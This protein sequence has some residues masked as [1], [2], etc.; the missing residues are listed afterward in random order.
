MA[1]YDELI[2]LALKSKGSFDL[3]EDDLVSFVKAGA[4]RAYK[5]GDPARQDEDVQ[6][7]FNVE[8][9]KL[10]LSLRKKVVEQVTNTH[11]ECTP[12]EGKLPVGEMASVE[13]ADEGTY[14]SIDA[15]I[16]AM[17]KE[18]EA[19]WKQANSDLVKNKFQEMKGACLPAQ[20]LEPDSIGSISVIINQLDAMLPA[21]EQVPGETFHVGQTVLVFVKDLVEGGNSSNIIVSRTAPEV[22]MQALK[23]HIPEVD[24]GNIEVKG[25]ARIPGK[26][27]RIAVFSN[28]MNA[29]ERCE[30]RIEKI[31]GE[32]GKEVVEFIEWYEDIKSFIV[33][34]LRVEARDVLLIEGE[35][36]AL[37]E[38]FKDAAEKVP[39]LQGVS[40]K[41]AEEL[42][43]YKL[44]IKLVARNAESELP[45]V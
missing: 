40:K 6:A 34:S 15:A 8:T 1:T 29:V 32:L 27:S 31:K 9:K 21:Q 5:A 10:R 33:S 7:D 19:G 12:E 16:S 26:C 4:I 14:K 13:I 18:I 22:V 44:D 25:I 28:D 39:D 30:K 17:R 43:G 3:Q 45:G 38:V 24:T 37:V 42:T 41:Q 23:L 2:S 11:T 35:K 36:Q 20:I